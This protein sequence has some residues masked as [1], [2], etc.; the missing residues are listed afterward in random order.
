M[1][2]QRVQPH[3]KE[4]QRHIVLGRDG[5]VVRTVSIVVVLGDRERPGIAVD[6]GSEDDREAPRA[7]ANREP[8]GTG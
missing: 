2:R 8:S 7:S 5:E 3:L 6:R 4:R 1:S